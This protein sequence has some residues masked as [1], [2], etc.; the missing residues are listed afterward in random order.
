M[1][2]SFRYFIQ[3][4]KNSSRYFIIS[5][6]Y[7]LDSLD[8]L[9]V[10]HLELVVLRCHLFYYMNLDSSNSESTEASFIFKSSSSIS[11]FITS[12]RT[13]K[14]TSKMSDIDSSSVNIDS[15]SLNTILIIKNLVDRV[16]VVVLRNIQKLNELND[17]Q[18]WDC[19]FMKLIKMQSLWNIL[20]NESD[21]SNDFI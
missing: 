17:W 15:S 12:E 7:E 21:N 2:N 9:S 16:F 13:F 11:E 1:L 20:I 8:S 18:K 19:L 10:Y 3:I 14:S 5:S 6:D 4:D